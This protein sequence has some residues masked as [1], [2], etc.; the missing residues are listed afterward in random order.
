MKKLTPI[1]VIIILT[2]LCASGVMAYTLFKSV[3]CDLTIIPAVKTIGFYMDAGCTQAFVAPIHFGNVAQGQVVTY[4]FYLRNESLV[5]TNL[6]AT[7]TPIDWGAVTF[8]PSGLP[9][10]MQPNDIY[11][12]TMIVTPNIT[13]TTGLKNLTVDFSD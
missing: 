12:L 13:A 8:S 4:D 2:L 10:L 7:V 1:L 6:N 5:A 11:K 9:H 3:G